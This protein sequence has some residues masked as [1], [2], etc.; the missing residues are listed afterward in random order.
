MKCQEPLLFQTL[1][2]S[3]VTEVFFAH[4]NEEYYREYYKV[5]AS[6]AVTMVKESKKN[7][8]L[9]KI[10]LLSISFSNIISLNRSYLNVLY[11]TNLLII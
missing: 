4:K 7:I 10:H 3:V 1:V 11:S 6:N 9:C 8:Y 5:A 2:A